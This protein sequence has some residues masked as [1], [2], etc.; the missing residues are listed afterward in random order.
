MLE[1]SLRVRVD[2]E[3]RDLDAGARI[4]IPRRLPFTRCANPTTS[5]PRP[6]EDVARRPHRAMVPSSRRPP[7]RGQG[8][9][10]RD[11]GAARF[12]RPAHQYDDVI[13]IA[14]G[15][16][17][18]LRIALTAL[19]PLG[20]ARGYLPAPPQ[21]AAR[22]RSTRTRR[23]ILP[24][25]RLRDLVDEL[26]SAHRLCGATRSATHAISSSGV[27]RVGARHDERLRELARLLVG[28]ADHGGVGDRGVACSSSAS[29]SAGATW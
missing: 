8:R 26:D 5:L 24:D 11:A 12:R 17:A 29:S 2:G 28:D 13:R 16:E 3:E 22:S 10:Q 7:R 23:R 14:V 4:E 6:L 20:R 9:P 21:E 25:G 15:P 1:G 18:P 27:E 19:A